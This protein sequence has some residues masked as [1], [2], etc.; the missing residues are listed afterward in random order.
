MITP[1]SGASPVFGWL[2]MALGLVGTAAMSLGCGA[3]A[4]LAE[5]RTGRLTVGVLAVEHTLDAMRFGDVRPTQ[6]TDFGGR[7][8]VAYAVTPVIELSVAGSA[9]R[10]HFHHDTGFEKGDWKDSDWSVE[11]GP[12]FHVGSAGRAMFAIGGCLSYGE[13]RSHL[14]VRNQLESFRFDGPVTF[15]VGGK[16]GL[17]VVVPLLSRID[18]IVRLS[19]GVVRARARAAPSGNLFEWNGRSLT[20][21][22]G[23]RV[24]LLSGDE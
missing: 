2:A 17:G 13:G 4:V 16:G 20:A 18:G 12:N 6:H 9:G 8:E 15:M 7:L 21:E 3:L 10:S 22:M 24:A 11:V 1:R 14:T 19:A 5:P 23:I